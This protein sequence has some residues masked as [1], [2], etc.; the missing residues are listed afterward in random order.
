MLNQSSNT[1]LITPRSHRPT[2]VVRSERRA[3]IRSTQKGNQIDAE[4]FAWLA[5][6]RS[7][8]RGL[9]L[10]PPRPLALKLASDR[11]PGP[12]CRGS[13]VHALRAPGS[14]RVGGASRGCSTAARA[15]VGKSYAPSAPHAGQGTPDAE[16][17]RGAPPCCRRAAP[18]RDRQGGEGRGGD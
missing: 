13:P 3:A 7:V 6:H 14:S 18:A 5:P 15:L 17:R 9:R 8:A 16:G 1:K 12:A 11:R 4:R 2:E 10:A